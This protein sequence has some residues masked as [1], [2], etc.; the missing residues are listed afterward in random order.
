MILAISMGDKN[1]QNKTKQ[2]WKNS[3]LIHKTTTNQ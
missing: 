2:N 3:F 1:K